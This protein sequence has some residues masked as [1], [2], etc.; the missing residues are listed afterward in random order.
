MVLFQK[1]INRI[2]LLCTAINLLAS[3][4]GLQKLPYEFSIKRNNFNTALVSDTTITFEALSPVDSSQLLVYDEMHMEKFARK[5][6]LKLNYLSDGIKLVGYANVERILNSKENEIV[7]INQV[8]S[9]I[10]SQRY[11]GLDWEDRYGKSVAS[12]LG[13][14]RSKPGNFQRKFFNPENTRDQQIQYIK[15]RRVR[16]IS[17]T[18]LIGV[19]LYLGS[20]PGP[21]L[22][23]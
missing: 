12:T 16:R 21:G 9:R 10:R 3:C 13:F 14:T 5:Q 7:R 1:H 4:S 2:V 6:N 11:I 15:V 8:I 22:S 19:L 20:L 23:F 17:A 18:V